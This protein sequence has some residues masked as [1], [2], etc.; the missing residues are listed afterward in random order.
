MGRTKKIGPAGGFKAR[1]GGTLR[2]RYVEVVSETKRPHSCPQCRAVAV[3]RQSVGIWKCRKCDF[4]FTGGA[5]T[6]ST[7]LGETAKRAARGVSAE[8]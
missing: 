1:Y 8:A 4:T 3:K 6:P 7:K 2:K 5:Y